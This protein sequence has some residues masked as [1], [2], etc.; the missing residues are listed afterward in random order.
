MA[1]G[2]MLQRKIS[3]SHDVAA[4]MV[5]VSDDLG[6]EHGPFAALLFTWCVA[7]LDCEGRMH[8]DPRLVRAE[9]FPLIDVITV[10]H[11][12]HYLSAMAKLEL[13][14][15]YEHKGRRWLAFPGFSD[16]QPGLRKDREKSTFPSPEEGSRILDGN[17]PATSRQ[18]AG[19]LPAEVKRSLSEVEEKI[20]IPD[21]PPASRAEFD[22]ESV[23]KSVYPRHEGKSGGMRAAKRQVTTQA[24]YERWCSAVKNY[25]AHVAGRATEHIKQFDSFMTCWEDYAEFKPSPQGVLPKFGNTA[26]SASFAEDGEVTGDYT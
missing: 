4:L 18:P 17:L 24:K 19:E 12:G 10:A 26:P 14:I 3:K 8:G 16:S 9:V 25:A 15:W 5:R 23:Y 21:S 13:V 20:T 1:S 22:F 7:H 6:L 2:R 11:V